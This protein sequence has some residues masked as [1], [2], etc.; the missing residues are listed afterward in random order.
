M[1]AGGGPRVPATGLPPTVRLAGGLAAGGLAWLV[2]GWV[3]AA[4]PLAVVLLIGGAAGL[5]GRRGGRPGR[6]DSTSGRT[7]S[8][9]AAKGDEDARERQDGDDA[10]DRE[11]REDGEDGKDG[12]DGDDGDDGKDGKD[13][14]D[15]EP[16]VL[17]VGDVLDLH[18]FSPRDVAG[19]VDGWLD[20]CVA[21]GFRQVRVIHGK[22]VGVQRRT[23]R[24]ILARRTDVASFWHDAGNWGATTVELEP[25]RR[26]E[27]GPEGIER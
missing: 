3:D 13:G 11:D 23:V 18:A 24:A 12:K 25:G 14:D 6:S 8:A 7:A 27:S 5:F 4:P 15:E 17:E 16:I 26:A 1:N 10:E 20:E 21:R 2:L 22:G 9:A 19:L